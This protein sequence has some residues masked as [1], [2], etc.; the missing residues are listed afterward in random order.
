MRLSSR[1][2]EV[3]YK[4]S[5][6]LQSRGGF[7][8]VVLRHSRTDIGPLRLDPRVCESGTETLLSGSGSWVQGCSSGWVIPRPEVRSPPVRPSGP[9]T[10]P[11]VATCASVSSTPTPTTS[12]TGAPSATRVTSCTCS[13]GAGASCR[14]SSP[15]TSSSPDP[16]SPS[17][18]HP[19]P[20]PSSLSL[21]MREL[22][23]TTVE[24]GRGR[25]SKG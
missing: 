23:G 21:G 18:S 13:R 2:I 22:P 17:L 4:L 11:V 3:N 12:G 1:I 16:V 24:R 15:L 14:S 8:W 19:S 25:E 7:L 20:T 10:R 9:G 6:S 5:V